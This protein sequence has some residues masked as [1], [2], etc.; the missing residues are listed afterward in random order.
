MFLSHCRSEPNLWR[1]RSQQ[2]EVIDSWPSGAPKRQSRSWVNKS[3]DPCLP[4]RACG[5]REKLNNDK[6]STWGFH[7]RASSSISWLINY[8]S[9]NNCLSTL[10][11][12]LHKQHYWHSKCTPHMGV[13]WF[14]SNPDLDGWSSTRPLCPLGSQPQVWWCPGPPPLQTS[15]L[16]VQASP[17]L[18]E[19]R[20]CCTLDYCFIIVKGYTLKVK[21]DKGRFAWQGVWRAPGA[22]LWGSSP[23]SGGTVLPPP[24]GDVWPTHILLCFKCV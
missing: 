8:L 14:Q 10:L 7:T 17:K 2:I 11:Q 13:Q 21:A 19:F 22:G 23:G 4:W 9:T 6:N 20:K 16:Q 5:V 3:A 18:T 12:V 24:G 15:G 1:L